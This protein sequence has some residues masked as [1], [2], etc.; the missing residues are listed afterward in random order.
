MNGNQPSDGSY[1]AVLKCSVACASGGS[2]LETESAGCT[3]DGLQIA[4]TLSATQLRMETLLLPLVYGLVLNQG[5]T[6][7][8]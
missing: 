3:S 8:R 7:G 6:T 2:K 4:S 5:P 1:S